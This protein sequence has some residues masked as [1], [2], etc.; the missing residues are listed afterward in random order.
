MNTNY[1]K[2][3]RIHIYKNSMTSQ[4]VKYKTFE[5]LCKPGSVSKYR[6]GKIG[7]LDNILMSD[8]IFTNSSKGN[9]AK[10]TELLAAFQTDN[11]MECIKIIMEKGEFS[12]TTLEKRDMTEKKKRE[13]IQ[14]IHTYYVD[15]K[16]GFPHPT[17]RIELALEQAKITSFDPFIPADKQIQVFWRKLNDIMPMKKVMMESIITIPVK[18]LGKCKNIIKQNGTVSGEK[19]QGDVCNMNVSFLPGSFDKLVQELSKMTNGEAQISI[20]TH[21]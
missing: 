7:S 5:V 15:P 10:K 1:V 11:V 4:V 19:V 13:I 16:S 9:R 17:I 14:D 18:Y 21:A 20:A 8:E 2:Y 3:T 6:E 12:L